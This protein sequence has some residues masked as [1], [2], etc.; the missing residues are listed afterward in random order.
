MIPQATGFPPVL[1]PP[2]VFTLAVLGGGVRMPLV[3]V[4]EAP[5]VAVVEA[6]PAVVPLAPPPPPYVP[7]VYPRKQDRN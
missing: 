5:P 2:A 3:Q 4:V 7:P 6:P 1:A